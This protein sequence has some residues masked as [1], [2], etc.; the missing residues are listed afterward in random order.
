VDK[1]TTQGIK[2]YRMGIDIHLKYISSQVMR[3]RKTKISRLR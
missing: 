2:V 3:I 1:L